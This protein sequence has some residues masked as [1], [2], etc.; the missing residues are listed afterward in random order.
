MN[1]HEFFN[2]FI[3]QVSHK[4][5]HDHIEHQLLTGRADVVLVKATTLYQIYKHNVFDIDGRLPLKEFYRVCG[6]YLYYDKYVCRHG[7]EF[8]Y[9]IVFNENNNIFKA[10][11]DLVLRRIELNSPS[12]LDDLEYIIG[13]EGVK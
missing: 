4:I 8:Y 2:D 12:T 3:S 10:T 1:N 5:N 7:T 6:Q 13:R 9:Y 11:K